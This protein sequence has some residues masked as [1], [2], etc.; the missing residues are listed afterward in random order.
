MSSQPSKNINMK[1]KVASLLAMFLMTTFV[2][3]SA[4]K[5]ITVEAINNDISYYLDLKAVASVFGEARNLEDFERRLNDY[6]AQIS[7]LD[8]NN[9]G[10]IDYLRVIE[11]RENNVHLVVIQA[12]L[13]R[14]IF[15]DVATIVV[16]KENNRQS[17]VQ[18]VG[19][20]YLY[21]YNYIVEPVYYRTPRIFSWFWSRSYR[22]WNSPFYWG[23]YPN[24]YRYRRPIEIN[25]YLSHVHHNINSRNYYR[26]SNNIRNERAYQS[27]R[28]IS[29]NDYSD[30]YPDR[31]FSNRNKEITNRASFDNRSRTNSS[32]NSY[33]RDNSDQSRRT[34]SI[35]N[36]RSSST[37]RQSTGSRTDNNRTDTRVTTPNRSN[38]ESTRTES[39]NRNTENNRVATPDRS[40]SESSR[41]G[42]NEVKTDNSRNSSTSSRPASSVQSRTNSERTVQAEKPA[43]R[44][45]SVKTNES[46]SRNNSS[47]ARISSESKQSVK[48]SSTPSSSRSSRNSSSN[49][50]NSESR[51]SSRR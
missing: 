50:S 41:T 3:L 7:N 17:Y 11:T 19:D 46:S 18:I 40:N 26:Y 29:R 35:E 12:I 9:D 31:R 45:E 1:T 32:T 30:R 38:S 28:S 10:E 49:K 24:Y 33:Q 48:S 43:S 8:L 14:D 37:N 27:Y 51:S 15:Q 42:R 44:N 21:G 25:I 4:I 16:E 2:Q 13:D 34:N 5:R 6:D 47:N 39:T 36:N 20:P 22:S 23:Y